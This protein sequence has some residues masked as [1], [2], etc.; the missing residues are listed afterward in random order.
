[1]SDKP[2]S[3]KDERA[4]PDVDEAR[5]EVLKKLGVYSAYVPPALVVML[6]ADKAVAQTGG[7]IPGGGVA[8]FTVF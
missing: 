8:G 5:R 3:S 2:E 7:G 4:A 1:M 6:T